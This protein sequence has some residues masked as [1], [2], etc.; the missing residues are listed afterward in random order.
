MD[1][2]RSP[3]VIRYTDRSVAYLVRNDGRLLV[4]VHANEERPWEQS[5]LQVPKGGIHPGETPEEGAL[6]ELAE[7]TG[8]TDV[9]VVRYL[10]SDEY[11]LRPYMDMVMHRHF[12]HLAID[13][14]VPDEWDYWEMGGANEVRDDGG[15][16]LRHYWLDISQCHALA[17]GLGA[18]LGRLA[19]SL[20]VESP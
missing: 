5:G 16:C 13:G 6:R 17:G 2:L 3:D 12:F 8:L 4:N 20:A 15:V 14:P 10:G 1:S 11:D 18:M 7:E 9:R 19:E